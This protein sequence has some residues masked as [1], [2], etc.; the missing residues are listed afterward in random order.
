MSASELDDFYVHTLTVETFTGTNGYGEDTF[1]APFIITPPEGC[2]IEPKRRLVRSSTGEQVISETT[3]Y[4]YPAN[5]ALFKPGSRVTLDDPENPAR[6]ITVSRFESGDLD[7]PDHV[8][9]NLT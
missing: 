3:V 8:V 4:T 9:V 7:L 2:F 1:A 6:V 5:A